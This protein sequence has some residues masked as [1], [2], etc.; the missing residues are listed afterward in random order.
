VSQ[1]DGLIREVRS[2]CD[3]RQ[4]QLVALTVLSPRQVPEAELRV[5]L[6]RDLDVLGL[7]DIDL[8]IVANGAPL[9]IQSAEFES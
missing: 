3:Q 6:L 7:G 2:L 4:G 9:R 8:T 5:A 1:V